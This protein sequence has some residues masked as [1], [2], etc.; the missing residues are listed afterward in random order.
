M[1]RR[2]MLFGKP[3]FK[4]L[5]QH[6]AEDKDFIG[7]ASLVLKLDD[8]AFAR[9]SGALRSSNAFLDR[10]GIAGIIREALGAD[11]DADAL[12]KS[13][14]NVAGLV[15]EA[16]LPAAEAMDLLARALEK[17]DAI[18]QGDR[19]PLIDRLRALAAEPAGL[20][21]QSKARELVGAIGC[22]LDECKII[23]DIRP[24]FDRTRERIEGLVPIAI[25]RLDYSRADGDEPEVIEMQ[26]TEKQIDE[27]CQTASDAKKKLI[28]IKELAESQGLPIPRTKST[29]TDKD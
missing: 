21:K 22:E 29:I 6:L 10:M 2:G 26:L 14:Y 4:F 27:L 28:A 25:L 23:C 16:D 3:P 17:S 8:I 13:I 24:V 20:A 7:E 12:A 9:L 19:T 5:A 15:H 1:P 11:V 18:P